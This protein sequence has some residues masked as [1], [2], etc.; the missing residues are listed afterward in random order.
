VNYWTHCSG[1]CV[2]NIS[3]KIFCINYFISVAETLAQIVPHQ[4]SAAAQCGNRWLRDVGL[5]SLE[6]DR[7]GHQSGVNRLARTSGT[8]WG[9]EDTCCPLSLWCLLCS[10]RAFCRVKAAQVLSTTS[11][12]YLI[13]LQYVAASFHLPSVSTAI[14]NTVQYTKPYQQY[15]IPKIPPVLF[16]SCCFLSPKS[17]MINYVAVKRG[18]QINSKVKRWWN[19]DWLNKKIN[20]SFIINSLNTRGLNF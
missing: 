16:Q 3:R 7:T 18:T 15:E 20:I 12:Q 11:C 2:Y 4:C 9:S 17:H 1:I 13:L 19:G 14:I 8:M 10:W 5:H 6:R